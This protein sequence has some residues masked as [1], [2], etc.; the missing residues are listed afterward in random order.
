MRMRDIR[1]P[2][3]EAVK[4]K[5]D[6][7]AQEAQSNAF[8]LV[9]ARLLRQAALANSKAMP[10]PPEIDSPIRFFRKMAGLRGADLKG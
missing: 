9:W 3:I 8:S 4:A 7:L 5:A 1:V 10:Q 6:E 2:A